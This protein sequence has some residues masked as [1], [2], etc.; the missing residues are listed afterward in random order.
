MT[1]AD[2]GNH[3]Y[4]EDGEIMTVPYWLLKQL[5]SDQRK[6]ANYMETFLK[7]SVGAIA[8][9]F[10]IPTPYQ[11]DRMNKLKQELE[12]ARIKKLEKAK[13]ISNKKLQK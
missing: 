1:Q 12:A 11:L 9:K 13:R 5:N 8:D 4:L 7:I 6:E 2:P 3:F 10:G